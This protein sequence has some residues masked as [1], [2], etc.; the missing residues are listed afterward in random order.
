[1]IAPAERRAPRL[2]RLPAEQPRRK[3]TARFRVEGRIDHAARHQV[4]IVEISPANTF[5]VRAWGR[6]KTYELALDT[7]ARMVVEAVVLAE[8]RKKREAKVAARKA[9]RAR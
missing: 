2:M 5:R 9:R 8:I 6:R 3:R 1:M 7:V 4:G